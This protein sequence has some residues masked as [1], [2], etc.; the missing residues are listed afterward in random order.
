[1][2]INIPNKVNQLI[3]TKL[4][5]FQSFSNKTDKGW[6][7]EL[8]FCIL[9]ANSKQKTAQQIQESLKDRLLTI[10]QSALALYIKNSKHRFHNNKAKYIIEARK[11]HPLK[12]KLTGNESENRN[13]LVN[14]IKGIGMKEAS[15]FLRNTGSQNLAILDRHILRT[16]EENNIISEMPKLLSQKQ[17]LIIEQKFQDLAKQLNMSP[18]RLDLMVWYLKTGKVAK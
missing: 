13:W 12:E 9:A 4:K 14:N 2:K 18:A 6:F 16:L 17:Y 1:M 8:C 3:D 15:H 10:N 5:E 7:Q 11:H